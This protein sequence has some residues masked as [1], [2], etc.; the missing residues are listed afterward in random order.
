MAE[1]K[2]FLIA[3]Y[4]SGL[5]KDLKP[6]MIPDD[7]FELLQNA[8]VWRERVRKR[9]GSTSLFG[10]G[11]APA[12]PQLLSRFRIN[13]GTTNG[14]GNFPAAPS[15]VP[16]IVF[17]VG[18]MFSIGQEMFTVN[19]TGAPAAMLS[20]GAGAGTYNT[21]DGAFTF[22]GAAAL[23]AVYFYPAEPAMGFG[24]LDTL[25][26]N[27]E[28]YIG[29]DTQFAYEYQATGGWERLALGAAL[30]T[31]G[32]GATNTQFF[33]SAMYRGLAADDLV[34]F[35]TNN[36][37]SNTGDGIRYFD[38]TTWIQ[39]TQSY[40]A[41]AN[42][43]ILGCRLIVQFKG[44]LVLLNLLEEPGAATTSRFQN[45]ARFSQVGTPIN[46]DSWHEAPGTYGKGGHVDAP[47]QEEIISA[48]ILRDRL[49]VYFERSTWE[50]AYTG[51]EIL[52]FL[53]QNINIELGSES[54]F[55]LIPFDK[56]ILGI[57]EVGIHTC[58]GVNVERI[59][60]KIP[61]D[62]YRIQN[63]NAGIERVFGIRDYDAELAYW[64][65]PNVNTP[66]TTAA[67]LIFPNRL[68]VY[69]YRNN[70]WARWDDSITAFGYINLNN[71]VTWSQLIQ[72]QWQN[73]GTPWGAG[74]NQAR[75]NRVLAGNQE[76]YT[77]YMGRGEFCNAPSRQITNITIGAPALTLRIIDHNLTTLDFILIKN[78]TGTGD[79][80]NLNDEIFSVGAI[81]DAN[82]IQ[83]FP[84]NVI[85]AVGVYSGGGTIATVSQITIR[86]K[87]FNFFVPEGQN[88]SIDQVDMLV[89]RTA[90]SEISVLVVPNTGSL[91]VQS[92]ILETR[93]YDPN[94]YP[95]EPFQDLLW[96]VIYPEAQGS[97]IQFEIGWDTDQMKDADISGS[98]FEL[99]AMI[100]HAMPTAARLQ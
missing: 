32:A 3:P 7:A 36:T 8:Y 92:L 11:P 5:Q 16:G 77:F 79:M 91:A 18:Q 82:N 33:Y 38:G 21:T 58:N 19:V 45:R 56:G 95:Y 39:L 75:Q 44:R 60:N 25:N 1:A 97:F 24:E 50:L 66:D 76:G 78:V 26:I 41:A 71:A 10:T 83:I 55:S 63:D 89:A 67:P 17:K 62:I 96:H 30:W 86:T 73:W 100:F 22:A 31:A 64:A 84:G 2:R 90:L 65:I 46:A 35:T 72:I 74:Q 14:G 54:T 43:L 98:N 28:R 57:G 6:W 49:I 70:S 42:T 37:P 34:L 15:M 4:N 48:Q 61:D 87:Q 99:H 85:V 51:N 94:I 47:T 29:Y 23:T 9:I 80:T 53:W 69:N 68:L 59:D 93:P 81:V 52:P 27:F 13:L 12:N 20:T 88:F 40:S